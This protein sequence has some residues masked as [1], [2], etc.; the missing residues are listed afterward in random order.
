MEQ[1]LVSVEVSKGVGVILV[2]NPPVNALSDEIAIRLLEALTNLEDNPQVM[3]VVLSASGST[4][5]AGADVSKFQRMIAEGSCGQGAGYYELTNAI[6]SFAKPIVCA[7]FGTT[8]G[9]GLELA[10]ACHYRLAHSKA[11]LGLPEVKLGL[12]PGAGGTQRLPRLVGILNAAEICALG[13]PVSAEKAVEWGLVDELVNL[14]ALESSDNW[15]SFIQS[16]IALA[17]K[18]S[19][20]PIRRT[21]ELSIP[22]KEATAV[23]QGISDLRNRCQEKFK[24]A[25]A[26]H[27]A[28]EAIEKSM[29][30]SLEDGLVI[31]NEI[32]VRALSSL[33]ARTLLEL[34]FAERAAKK[35]PV[36][37]SGTQPLPFNQIVFDH[38]SEKDVK[39]LEPMLRQKISIEL[40]SPTESGEQAK[41]DLKN[42]LPGSIFFLDDFSQET[43]QIVKNLEPSLMVC[44][45]NEFRIDQMDEDIIDLRLMMGLKMTRLATA[46]DRSTFAE[47]AI[48]DQTIP[49]GIATMVQLLKKMRLPFVVEKPCP[50]Y[51]SDRIRAYRHNPSDL[52]IE[53]WKLLNDGVVSRLSDI[54]VVQVYG[55]GLPRHHANVALSLE[56]FRN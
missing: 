28:I 41:R 26:S 19:N 37:S 9:G 16:A 36:V 52:K 5:V 54:D 51:V 25:A 46:G 14:P 55:F 6:E 44:T 32:F 33:E 23:D 20:E 1:Q 27:L 34:F 45:S 48:T 39:I 15:Q 11:L 38:L 8:L 50:E 40:L 47:L 30:L 10:L 29:D 22:S 13:E 12:I 24:G 42:D 49:Q 2:D 21:G 53:A 18:A 56:N 35:I 7:L 31:E 3:A 43:L 17:L 4:F